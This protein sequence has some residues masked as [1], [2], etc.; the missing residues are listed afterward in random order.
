M[1]RQV[2]RILLSTAVWLCICTMGAAQEPGMASYAK[3]S[4]IELKFNGPDSQAR[5]TP[6]PFAIPFDVIFTAPSGN[7]FRVPGFYNGD[8]SGASDGKVWKVRFAADELGTW[9]WRSQ[10]TATQ[11]D[12][13]SGRFGVTATT[14]TSGHGWG[15]RRSKPNPMAG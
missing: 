6:N 15:R 14:T 3:W 2:A 9:S 12:G 4:T 8:G 7:T 11:L 10:S 5:G 13:A 1:P